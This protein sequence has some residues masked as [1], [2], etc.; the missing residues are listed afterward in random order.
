MVSRKKVKGHCRKKKSIKQVDN[1]TN[2]Y[3]LLSIFGNGINKTHIVKDT[4]NKRIITYTEICNRIGRHP[5]EK[6]LNKL[7]NI[8]E[9][10]ITDFIDVILGESCILCNNYYNNYL[11]ILHLENIT[12]SSNALL[13]NDNNAL[14]KICKKCLKSK[15]INKKYFDIYVY[16][17]TLFNYTTVTIKNLNC[18]TCSISYDIVNFTKIMAE[19][20]GDEIITKLNKFCK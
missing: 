1:N 16:L 3:S 11:F 12:T 7:E 18:N 2:D 10:G 20:K 6:I 15:T 5:N 19:F 13:E 8:L 4:N 14:L 17:T 9:N